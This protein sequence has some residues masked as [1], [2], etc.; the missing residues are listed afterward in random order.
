MI[1]I[2]NK[3]HKWYLKIIKKARNRKLLKDNYYEKHHIIPKSFKD[4]LLNF[5][6]NFKNNL[7]SLT[8]KEHYICHLLLTKF[9]IGNNKH[10]MIYAFDYMQSSP[11][12]NKKRGKKITGAM[13]QLNK[14]KANELRKKVKQY[15]KD[16]GSYN[17]IWIHHLEKEN[18][19]RVPKILLDKYLNLGYIKGRCLN[20]NKRKNKLEN[21]FIKKQNELDKE[22]Q[23]YYL[24]KRKFKFLRAE[25]WQNTKQ[26]F[27]IKYS[28]QKLNKYF[29]NYGLS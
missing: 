9:C 8:A 10:K 28:Y 24:F 20:F 11:N 25:G 21:D 15:G 7:V 26:K 18:N 19:L 12:N 6:F 22:L 5:N 27:N 17:T 2:K 16:N 1:F 13:F 14:I 29:I 3:Y 4:T 23:K